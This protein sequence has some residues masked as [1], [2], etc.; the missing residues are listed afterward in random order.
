MALYLAPNFFGGEAEV[1]YSR[2][3]PSGGEDNGMTTLASYPHAVS[4]LL[5]TYAEPHT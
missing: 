4:W 1:R 2:N 5:S 3:L